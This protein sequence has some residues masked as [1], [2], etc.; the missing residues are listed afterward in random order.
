M[1]GFVNIRGMDATFRRM[2]DVS[3]TVKEEGSRE[4]FENTTVLEVPVQQ[5]RP[6]LYPRYYRCVPDEEQ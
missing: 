6:L 5:Y 3:P 4:L 1:T 2:C